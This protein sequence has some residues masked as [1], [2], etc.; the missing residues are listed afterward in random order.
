VYYLRP[1]PN[2]QGYLISEYAATSEDKNA[3]DWAEFIQANVNISD[4]IPQ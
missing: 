2:G 3:E 4:V 1:K